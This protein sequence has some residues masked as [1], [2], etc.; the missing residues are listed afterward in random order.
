[1]LYTQGN[2]VTRIQCAFVDTPE[3][4]KITDFIGSQRAYPEAYLRPEYVGE[5][6]SST[7]D[8]NISERD[9]M[10]REAAE[11]I[12]IAQQGSASLIQRKLKLGYNRAGRI[13]DQLEA[14][15]IVGPF[16]GS[17]ARQVLIQDLIGLQQLLDNEIQK[18]E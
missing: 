11:V 3:V 6:G 5:E 14:A 13:V 2:D 7:V 18:N 4:E 15:G 17:K 9:A 10:F 8:Y 12:V 1:M 16:E